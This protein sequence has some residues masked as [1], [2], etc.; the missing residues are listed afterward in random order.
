ML[1][2][3]T[4]TAIALLVFCLY[5]CSDTTYDDTNLWAEIE[6]VKERVESLEK[7]VTATNDNLIT[8][9]QIIQALQ[10]DI[11]I[12]DVTPTNNGY[13]ITFSDNTVATITNGIDGVNAP[14]ISV[15]QDDTDGNYYWTLD[16]EWLLIDGAK[17]QANGI[18]GKDG[19]N[20]NDGKDATAPQIR[21]N[22]TSKEWE[23]S[24]DGGV[25]WSST[26]VIAEGKDGAT[27]NNGTNGDSLF[28]TIDLSNDN[29]VTITLTNGESFKLAR[30]NQDT[31]SFVINE[32]PEEVVLEYGDSICFEVTTQNVIDYVINAPEGWSVTYDNTLTI[33]A[34]TKDLCHFAKE[35]QIAITTISESGRS[36]ITKLKVRTGEWIDQVT[37]RTLTFEDSDTKFTSYAL[38]PSGKPIVKW[39]DLVDDAQYG[40]TLTYGDYSGSDYYWYDEGNT[41]LFHSFTTPYWGGGHVI[42][43]YV[44]KDFTPLPEGY[45]GWYELQMCTP[46]GGNNGSANFAVH[47]GYSDSFN[48]QLYDSS[49]HG[50]EFADG[51]ERVIDHMYVTNT[52]YVLNSLLFGDGF[53]SP[54]TDDTYFKIVA[55]GFNAND[56]QVGS[57]E[58]TLCDG[59]DDIITEWTKWDLKALGK[60]A[61]VAFNFTASADQIG[62]YGM[63]SP[64]YF[65]YDDVEV[66]FTE[67]IF[68]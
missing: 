26:G 37:L 17:V 57:L 56:E 25:T 58:F 63:N 8:L 64:A 32:A 12:K 14:T 5:G 67:R 48:S 61:R 50:F 38:E 41:E 46:I 62:D 13:T 21:I 22:S 7:S 40:G 1:R 11:T 60:V 18:D 65:A 44:I 20:G 55:Y 15:A 24:A 10:Q 30:Y 33:K 9:Q 49:L 52:N 47:N 2:F 42:S 53:N 23:I 16:G 51:T 68:K 43:N 28:K 19:Q 39:S 31:P 66:Q 35:G 54:A 36:A 45:N 29:F 6:S 4:F 59:T 34:P 27:G 3:R